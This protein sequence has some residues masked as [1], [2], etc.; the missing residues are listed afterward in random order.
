MIGYAKELRKF[1]IAGGQKPT[2]PRIIVMAAQGFQQLVDKPTHIKGNILDHL[3]VRD[4]ENPS[5]KFHHPYYSDH[6]AICF[7]AKL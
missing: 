6:D 3:Y 5:W 1:I 4:L 7:W 2:P